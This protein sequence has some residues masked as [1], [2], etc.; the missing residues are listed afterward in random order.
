MTIVNYTPTNDSNTLYIQYTSSLSDLITQIRE[1]F[2]PD[3]SF[4]DIT[5]TPEYIHTRCLTYDCYDR[6]D[7]DNYLVIR[8]I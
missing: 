5:I 8:R 3:I 4:D 7:Y 2:G 6:S 1:H